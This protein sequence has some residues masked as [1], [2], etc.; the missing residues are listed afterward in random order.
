MGKL[1][2]WSNKITKLEQTYG[3]DVHK[4]HLLGIAEKAWGKKIALRVTDLLDAYQ[5]A[6]RATTHK[7]IKDLIA[8]ELFRVVGSE[9]DGRVRFLQ[10]G[11]RLAQLE[12][13]L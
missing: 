9:E 6:A 12:K 5:N 13:M 3:V 11:K 2:K 4:M 8:Q 7:A 10:P 1:T